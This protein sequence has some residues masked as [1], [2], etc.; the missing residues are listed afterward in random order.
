MFLKNEGKKEMV[1]S[2]YA[3]YLFGLPLASYP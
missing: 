3:V 2:H 1:I